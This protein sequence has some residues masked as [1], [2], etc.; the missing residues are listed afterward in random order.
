MPLAGTR[1]THRMMPYLGAIYRFAGISERGMA[2]VTCD[3]WINE[4]PMA[5]HPA[6]LDRFFTY[7]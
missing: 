1:M 4:G 7:D 2:L 6:L 5:L 3:R